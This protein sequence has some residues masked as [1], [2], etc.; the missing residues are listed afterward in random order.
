M[1]ETL[2]RA[3]SLWLRSPAPS[4]TSFVQVLSTSRTRPQKEMPLATTSSQRFSKS[5]PLDFRASSLAAR[6]SSCMQ[7]E[8]PK[9]TLRDS[10]S[11]PVSRRY[12]EPWVGM[13]ARMVIDRP[14]LLVARDGILQ[15]MLKMEIET[16]SKALLGQQRPRV[17]VRCRC[18]SQHYPPRPSFDLPLPLPL[19]LSLP[20]PLPLPLPV[21]PSLTLSSIPSYGPHTLKSELGN[22]SSETRTT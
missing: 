3:R 22:T 18:L 1:D 4:F 10:P 13:T 5:T 11:L 6:E 2:R 16:G 12:N 9:S 14:E 21:S 20:L 8:G 7:G 19:P 17:F 15:Y